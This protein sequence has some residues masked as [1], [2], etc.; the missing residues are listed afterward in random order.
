MKKIIAL[1]LLFSICSFSTSAQD[2]TYTPWGDNFL[3]FIADKDGLGLTDE[4]KKILI[5]AMY[6]SLS[7]E[8]FGLVRATLNEK[9]GFID[10]ANKTVLPFIYDI[11]TNSI[12][13]ARIIYSDDMN[14][15]G[16]LQSRTF[17][18]TLKHEYTNFT[19]EGLCAVILNGK[20]GFI[21]TL[22]N[23]KIPFLFNGA[24]NFFDSIAIVKVND[25]YGAINVNGEYVIP[26]EYDMLAHT[27]GWGR[28]YAS[29]DRTSFYINNK[30]QRVEEI[31]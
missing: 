30:G 8:N 22:G 11:D 25:K 24:D 19:E 14:D 20:Y 7:F 26:L 27:D 21:D 4:N 18:I 15:E 5:P 17:Y 23:T 6:T 1:L 12:I 28:I 9:V 31:W 3:F 16:Q 13:G 2:T 10:L 29:K